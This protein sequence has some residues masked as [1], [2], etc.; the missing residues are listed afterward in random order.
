MFREHVQI[1]SPSHAP[2]PLHCCPFEPRSHCTLH[3]APCH[4]AAHP[5][6]AAPAK[7]PVLLPLTH[8]HDALLAWHLP[9][10]LHG[11]ATPPGHAL[12]QSAPAYPKSQLQLA[13]SAALATHCPCPPHTVPP[14]RPGHA[15]LQSAPP[16][17]ASHAHAPPV[18][19][20]HVPCPLHGFAAPPGHTWLQSAVAYPAAH[21]HVPSPLCP[22][23]HVPCP[24][25]GVAAPPGHSP[26]H[27]APKYP[28][29]HGPHVPGPSTTSHC[30]PQYPASHV[31]T[32]LAASQT[33]RPLHAGQ[34]VPFASAHDT[35]D[36]VDGHTSPHAAPFQPGSHATHVPFAHCPCPL[37]G[38]AAPGHATRQPALSDAL[39]ATSQRSHAAPAQ[40]PE[41]ASL[42]HSHASVALLHVP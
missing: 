7:C 36:V 33:P 39:C 24:L 19:A 35:P 12:V 41:T 34:L 31:H 22:S 10:R 13:P 5:S 1:A 32:P 26:A 28:A 38:A 16:Y 42:A 23:E 2:C 40:K 15:T 27:A 14:S 18:V 4:S 17:C 9:R 37:H 6:H 20:S 3:D 30:R 25:Q 11:V 8:V 29:P 21:V